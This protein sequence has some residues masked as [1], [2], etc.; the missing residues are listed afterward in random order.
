MVLWDVKEMAS[1]AVYLLPEIP[2]ISTM[3]REEIVKNNVKRKML[4]FDKWK[5]NFSFLNSFLSFSSSPFVIKLN[6]MVD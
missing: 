4:Q 6:V 1:K 3:Q 5:G 2:E